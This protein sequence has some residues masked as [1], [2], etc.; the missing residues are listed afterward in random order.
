[1]YF[2]IFLNDIGCLILML[3]VLFLWLFVVNIL[4][5]VFV[6]L[7]WSIKFIFLLFVGIKMVLVFNICL[8]I[9]F[10]SIFK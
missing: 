9:K 6:I 10:I 5:S 8:F 7:L 3:Y 1:M 2:V 4:V